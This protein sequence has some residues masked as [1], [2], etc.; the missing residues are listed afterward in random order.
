MRFLLCLGVEP[1]RVEPGKPYHK[2]FAEHSVR[3]LNHECLW[4]DPPHDHL[5]AAGILEVYRHFYNHDRA[6]QSL[7]CGNRPPFEAFPELPHL[8]HIYVGHQYSKERVGIMLDAEKRVFYV[9]HKGLVIREL[10]IAD[11]IGKPMP[12]QDYL[13]RMLEEAR[14]LNAD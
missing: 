5:D 9:L 11:L 2:P 1:D 12:F 6:N 7:A 13:K 8:P 4:I 10:E 3:T 14:T